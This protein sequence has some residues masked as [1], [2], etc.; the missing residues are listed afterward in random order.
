MRLKLKNVTWGAST[1]T[2]TTA[3]DAQHG[4]AYAGAIDWRIPHQSQVRVSTF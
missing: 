4:A 2:D 3:T 1:H